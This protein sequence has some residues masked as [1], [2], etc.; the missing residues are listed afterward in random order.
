P[1]R[2]GHPLTV[3][4]FAR[5]CPEKGFQNVV[6]AFIR[7]RQTPGAPPAKLRVSGWLGANHHPFF[8]EQVKKLTATGLAADFEHVECPT[9]ADKVLFLQS[10]DVLSVPTTYREPKGL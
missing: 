2:T 4:Y 1:V 6:D 3:G 8:D 10:V 9:H 7:L 5:I